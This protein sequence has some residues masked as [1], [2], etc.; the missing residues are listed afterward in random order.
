MGVMRTTFYTFTCDQPGCDVDSEEYV[1][2]NI[3]A[4]EAA[5]R[6]TRWARQQASKDGWTTFSDRELCPE[7]SGKRG[8]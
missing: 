1:Y 3:A 6:G 2:D 8:R 7:H 5:G 4:Q